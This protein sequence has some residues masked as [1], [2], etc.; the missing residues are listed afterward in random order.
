M[1]FSKRLL[2]FPLILATLGVTLLAASSGEKLKQVN[3]KYVCFINK[4]HFDKPQKEVV[5]DGR[6]YYGCCEDCIKQLTDDPASRVAIDPINGREIDKAGAV[7]G[8]DKAG[9]VYFFQ[10]S[11]HLKKFR[12]PAEIPSGQ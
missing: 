4:K 7:V 9:N 5:I 2:A 8:I 3:A 6:K 1:A 10:N 12:V 11:D